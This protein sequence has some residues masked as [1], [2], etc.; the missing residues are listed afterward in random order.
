VTPRQPRDPGP[1]DA[2]GW[3]ADVS[4]D[5]IG[6]GVTA[7][8]GMRADA[9][10]VVYVTALDAAGI[11]RVHVSIPA[12]TAGP[13]E[14]EGIRMPREVAAALYLGLMDYFG[15]PPPD[16]RTRVDLEIERARVDRLVEHLAA[17]AVAAAGV[18]P[19]QYA[20]VPANPEQDA[21][22]R[23]HFAEVLAERAKATA[24]PDPEPAQ[25]H[26]PAT[27]GGAAP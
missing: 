24:W 20:L 14:P 1:V 11:E 6:L 2:G 16:R 22:A 19:A 15:P 8:I 3:R 18:P 27:E 26:A 21:A 12:G 23:A 7:R 5:P 10:R 13:A 25:Q 4:G 17:V 9:D